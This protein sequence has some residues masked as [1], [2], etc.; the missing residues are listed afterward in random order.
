MGTTAPG[1]AGL[2]GY[3]RATE[4]NETD[5]VSEEPT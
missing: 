1:L 2:N 3:E 4:Q 5:L